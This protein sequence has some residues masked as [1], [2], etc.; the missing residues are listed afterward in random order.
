MSQPR[1]A[2]AVAGALALL[3]VLALSAGCAATPAAGGVQVQVLAAL[4]DAYQHTTALPAVAADVTETLQSGAS[5]VLA[6]QGSVVL[7]FARRTGQTQLT[8]GGTRTV[9]AVRVGDV[10]FEASTPAALNGQGHDLAQAGQQDPDTLPQI[11]APGLD[12]FQLTTLLGAVAW[13]DSVTGLEPVVSEDATGQHTAYQV[14]VDTAKLAAHEP[15][16]DRTWLDALA[17]RP[18]GA[19]VTLSATVSQGRLDTVSAQLPVPAPALPPRASALPTPAPLSVLV[20]EQFSYTR[21][22]A[23]ITTPT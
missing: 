21:R 5:P 1:P 8:V 10:F 19:V 12:P 20:A 15:P 6:G 4:R 11:Q 22:P 16:G 3:S 13:S 2:A 9:V 14:G 18:G 17:H 23:A 7:E